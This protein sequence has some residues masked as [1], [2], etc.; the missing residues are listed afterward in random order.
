MYEKARKM[1]ACRKDGCQCTERINQKKIERG[2]DRY[3]KTAATM[4]NPFIFK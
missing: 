3:F 1:S 2:D 4:C